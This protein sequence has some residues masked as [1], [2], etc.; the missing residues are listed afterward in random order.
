MTSLYCETSQ[1]RA[2]VCMLPLN[3]LRKDSA[4]LQVFRAYNPEQGQRNSC[5]PWLQH[6]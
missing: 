4:L 1:R 3:F 6:P 2:K 5:A